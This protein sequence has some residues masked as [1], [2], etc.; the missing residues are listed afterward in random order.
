MAAQRFFQDNADPTKLLSI[1]PAAISTGTER[2]L[3]FPDQSIDFSYATMTTVTA[4]PGDFILVR[5]ATDGLLK[6]VDAA[7]LLAANALIFQGTWDASSGTF[8]GGGTA[9]TG[10]LWVVSVGG[11]VDGV[12]FSAGD[13]LYSRTDNASENTYA[14]NWVHIDSSDSV[15]SVFGRVGAV[16]AV[17]GDYTAAQVTNT[18]SGDIAAT[19]VQA[20]IDELDAEKM[21]S[22]LASAQI[23][24]GNV[25]DVATAVA[26]TGH[27]S[28]TNA[29]VTTVQS[30][31]DAQ[32]GVV[33]LATDAEV[34]TG[35]D[36]TRAVTPASL[37][38]NYRRS[39]DLVAVTNGQGASL[40]GVE[41]A[42]AYYT[43]VTVE[44][45]LQEVGARLLDNA[46]REDYT[47]TNLTTDRTIDCDSVT[48]QEL[49]D[50]VGQ[51]IT[52]L[53]AKGIFQ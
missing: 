13:T 4:A 44:A 47:V 43:G 6:R 41:D 20:A 45:A 8:P 46:V 28:I 14:G 23:F 35:T 16:V 18:P 3:T 34:A 36:D 22:V 37:L 48:V 2:V 17:A 33:E 32:V 24:V 1:D 30:A 12:T 52:D 38:A 29:G 5:D 9:E 26:M 51:M 7:D 21:S 53:I 42:G 11:T 50:V 19:T 27:V 15:N 39:T 40:I 49:A 25:S 31:T 10:H